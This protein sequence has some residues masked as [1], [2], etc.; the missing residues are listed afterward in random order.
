MLSFVVGKMKTVYEC[1]GYG[2]D[3]RLRLWMASKGDE[4]NKF[5]EVELTEKMKVAFPPVV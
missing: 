3:Q 1:S 4:V 2:D 5:G